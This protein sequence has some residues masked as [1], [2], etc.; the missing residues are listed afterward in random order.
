MAIQAEAATI[1]AAAQDTRAAK[2]QTAAALRQL[3]DTVAA[4]APSWQGMAGTQFQRVMTS[5]NE[6]T[7]KLVNA[8]EAIATSLDESGTQ[9]TATDEAQQQAFNKFSGI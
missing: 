3:Y 6:Q 2:E 1:H 9:I 7:T 4:T 8:M 5:W